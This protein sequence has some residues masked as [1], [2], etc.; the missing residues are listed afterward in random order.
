MAT[1]DVEFNPK[2]YDQ[3]F[4]AVL[5]DYPS[6]LENLRQDF[7]DYIASDRM[8]LPHYFGKES[9]YMQPYAAQKAGLMHIHIAMPPTTF[10]KNK[11]QFD[12]KCPMGEPNQDAALVYA[13]GELDESKYSLIALLHPDA[14][15]QARNS[16][17]MQILINAAE[18]FQ[19]RHF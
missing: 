17:T 6:L 2:T 13:Q 15:G 5:A 10:T 9:P 1:I 16:K 14:H 12:R 4:A 18:D 7:I 19:E 3:L 8:N 11:P